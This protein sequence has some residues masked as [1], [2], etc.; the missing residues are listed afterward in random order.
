MQNDRVAQKQLY[1]N[2]RSYL[3]SVAYRYM[4]DIGIA[5]DVL[6]NGYIKI[7]KNLA[8]FSPSKGLFKNWAARII[9]NEALQIKRQRRELEISEDTEIVEAYT[10]IPALDKMTI[11]ELSRV[12]DTLP[13]VHR[14]ILNM[15]YFEEY[16][17]Q[18]IAAIL[19]I[20]SSSSRA[21]L[22]KARKLLQKKWKA[23]NQAI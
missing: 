9:V 5:Q 2:S 6:Q 3:M 19:N 23:Y 17:H 16:T 15:Y 14:I 13:S 20:K 11:E 7:F 21:Q 1:Q 8:E 22:S 10:H 12:I 18:E 4:K